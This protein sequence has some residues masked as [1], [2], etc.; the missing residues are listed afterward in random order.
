M[1]VWLRNESRGYTYHDVNYKAKRLSMSAHNRHSSCRAA[2]RLIKP[3]WKDVTYACVG[4]PKAIKGVS[5]RHSVRIS[6]RSTDHV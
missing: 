2:V 6:V 5:Y 1:P 4:E 3:Q